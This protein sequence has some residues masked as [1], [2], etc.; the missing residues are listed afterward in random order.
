M[1][2]AIKWAHLRDMAR[3]LGCTVSIR[4]GEYRCNR[5]G[6]P[7]ALAYYTNDAQDALET[8]QEMYVGHLIVTDTPR[9][10]HHGFMSA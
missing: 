3:N 10:V 1:R 4:D 2:H 8:M 6:A 5:R 9:A 7:E